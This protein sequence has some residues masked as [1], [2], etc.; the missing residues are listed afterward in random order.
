MHS[1]WHFDTCADKNLIPLT[2][3]QPQ[4]NTATKIQ[5]YQLIKPGI[6]KRKATVQTPKHDNIRRYS[7]ITYVYL[8]QTNNTKTTRGRPIVKKKPNKIM[9][10]I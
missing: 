5:P 6:H 2:K 4:I 7:P 1:A 10:D 9:S 8:L 3:F